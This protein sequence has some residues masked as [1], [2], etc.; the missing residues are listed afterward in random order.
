LTAAL[1]LVEYLPG[2]YP[3]QRNRL[4]MVFAD[5]ARR[6]TPGGVLDIPF[7]ADARSVPN[8]RAQTVHRKPIAGGYLSTVPPGPLAFIETDAVLS[9][10]YGL[11]P[12]YRRP[13]TREAL[14]ALGFDTVILHKD[15]AESVV[16][17]KRATL[18]VKSLFHARAAERLRG[19]PDAT[20]TRLRT[21]LERIAGPPLFEDEA[22]AVFVVTATSD[23]AGS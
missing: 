11:D 21:D 5:L 10:L 18:D 1:I 2:P 23:P 19:V 9:D 3:M 6:T 13:L 14:R 4:P 15:R 17:A 7:T 20:L 8:M 12:P 22:L 16:A